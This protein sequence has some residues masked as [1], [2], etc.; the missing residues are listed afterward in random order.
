MGMFTLFKEGGMAN[1]YEVEY[2][3]K[4]CIKK[5]IKDMDSQREFVRLRRE[6]DILKDLNHPN[7][8]RV[9][10]ID[11]ASYIME[12]ADCDFNEYVLNVKLSPTDKERII[13]EI[14][15]G[16]E[17]LHAH[18][19]VHRDLKPSNILMFKGHAKI[20]DLGICKEL[21]RHTYTTSVASRE[22]M[23]SM[24][25]MSVG[26]LSGARPSFFFD[27][28]ALGR[29]IYFME[30]K[31]NPLSIQIQDM[32]ESPYRS[33]VFAAQKENP[34][35]IPTIDAFKERFQRL[36]DIPIDSSYAVD[37]LYLHNEIDIYQLIDLL[38]DNGDTEYDFL[39]AVFDKIL[40]KINIRENDELKV[41]YDIYRDSVEEYISGHSW[42]FA[43]SLVICKKILEIYKKASVASLKEDLLF[44]AFRYPY[45]ASRYEALEYYIAFVRDNNLYPEVTR[46]LLARDNNYY[47][48]FLD[49]WKRR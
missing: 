48:C 16:I 27:I 18:Q 24:G 39:Q 34:I 35:L 14:V 42:S 10:D 33:I 36:N 17:I 8:V 38:K 41:L 4:T 44:S 28:F 26:Q 7:I 40:Q 45:E 37:V 32:C 49:Y 30:E 6:Y 19:I 12:R 3:G 23:G 2:N 46:L 25:Y 31:K 20:A 9:Y 43:E 22:G 1:L 5:Q 13:N 29:I 47:E 11:G 15:A 21:D